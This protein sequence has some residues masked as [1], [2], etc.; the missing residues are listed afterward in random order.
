MIKINFFDGKEALE[1]DCETIKEAVEK[2]IKQNIDLRHANLRHA[3]LRHA[4]LR[5]ADLH[6]ADLSYS[7]L[8]SAKLNSANLRYSNLRYSDLRSADLHY[9]DLHYSDLSNANLTGAALDYSCL[10]LWCGSLGMKIDKR[11]F[12]Q[13]LYHVV[14]AGQSIDDKEVK[15]LMSLKSVKALANQFHRVAECGEIE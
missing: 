1:F 9:A 2:A 15:K 5:H 13:L 4:N 11:I 12:C 6:Y 3:D 7:D 10:P 14:R 8:R